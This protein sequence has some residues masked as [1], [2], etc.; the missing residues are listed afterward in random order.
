MPLRI[1]PR[2]EK[3][4]ADLIAMPRDKRQRLRELI[5]TSPPVLDRDKLATDIASTTE[6]AK[7]KAAT[8]VSMLMSLY[9]VIQDTPI[10]EFVEELCDA[11]RTSRKVEA[12][13]VDWSSLKQDFT[14]L[15]S[16]DE[17]FGLTA[18]AFDIRKQHPHVYCTA[19]I[20]TDIR[21]VFRQDPEA[22]PVAAFVTHALRI[23]SHDEGDFS[24]VKDFF[25]SLDADDLR[26]LRK[27]IDRALMK[28]AS[29]KSLIQT[30]DVQYLDLEGH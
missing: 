10:D 13:E 24:G 20:L 2:F 18:K 26:E 8:I 11:A 21:P 17:T 28:E 5:R 25:V 3:S 29:L 1:P 7:A 30:S 19:R 23:S 9:R 4:L 15:L 27:L 12:K 16:C 6:L 22:A 14:A